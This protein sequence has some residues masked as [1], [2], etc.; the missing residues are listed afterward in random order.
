MSNLSLRTKH[1]LHQRCQLTVHHRDKWITTGA[2]S[3]GEKRWPE[4]LGTLVE[5]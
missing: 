5:T 3:G 4:V 1:H 2:F